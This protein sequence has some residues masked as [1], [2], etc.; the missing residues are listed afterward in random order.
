MG[1]MLV[2][3]T[4]DNVH[5]PDMET[6]AGTW[7][8]YAQEFS[9]EFHT[10]VP[11]VQE[12]L[13]GPVVVPTKVRIES[14]HIEHSGYVRLLTEGFSVDDPFVVDILGMPIEIGDMLV[15]QVE[16]AAFPSG[17][18]YVKKENFDIQAGNYRTRGSLEGTISKDGTLSL[19][20]KYRPGTMPFEIVTEFRQ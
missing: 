1:I 14:F 2:S 11:V 15:E 10:T 9:G 17:G 16:Y 20:M 3:C 12:Y 8:T 6:S 7:E 5:M 19:V 4:Q 18:G 13:Q